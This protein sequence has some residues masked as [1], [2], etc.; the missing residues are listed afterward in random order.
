[1]TGPLDTTQLDA[2]KVLIDQLFTS[3]RRD[4][5]VT[6]FGEILQHDGTNRTLKDYITKYV[7]GTPSD[8][9][10]NATSGIGEK[11]ALTAKYVFA[12]TSNLGVQ[13]GL[14]MWVSGDPTR[15]IGWKIC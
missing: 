15:G 6:L 1:M 9:P 2:A 12:D 4:S 8:E 3:G 7:K 10:S 11:L 13:A 5:L 14:R